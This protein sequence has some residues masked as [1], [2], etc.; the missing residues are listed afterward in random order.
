MY[1]SRDAVVD[2]GTVEEIGMLEH[3][4]S[5][6]GGNL[7]PYYEGIVVAFKDSV[8]GGVVKPFPGWWNIGPFA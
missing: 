6:S 8:V 7:G 4:G 2:T 3:S 1:S 5:C